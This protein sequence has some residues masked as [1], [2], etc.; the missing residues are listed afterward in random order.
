[1]KQLHGPPTPMSTGNS[2]NLILT[3]RNVSL[4]P[5]GITKHKVVQEQ[6]QNRLAFATSGRPVVPFQL[7]K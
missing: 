5:V 7:L 1:M 4:H 6:L 3:L 2:A